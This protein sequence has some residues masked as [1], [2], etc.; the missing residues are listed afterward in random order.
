MGKRGKILI[1][2]AHG[3]VGGI[4]AKNLPYDL[5]TPTRSELDL[6][7]KEQVDQ[8]FL[9]HNIDAVIHCALTGREVLFSTEPEYTVDSLW[10]FRNLWNNKHRF[11]KLINLGTAYEFDLTKDNTLVKESDMLMHLPNTSYG[12]AKNIITRIIK[13]TDEFYNLRLFGVFHPEEANNR[14]FKKLLINR[15]ITISN[16]I[17]LDY[18]YLEDIIKFIVPIIEHRLFWKDL[19]LV[20][21]DK[22]KLSEL[23]RLFCEVQG[24]NP[25]NVKVTGVGNN[26]LTGDSSYIQTCGIMLTPFKEAFSLYKV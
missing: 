19:N 11:K 4:I 3:F 8:Y 12:Y 1:T 24:I 21:T 5:L 26:N 2:G 6:S 20:H 18:I 14:F 17:Y 25:D 9:E 23:A 10:M 13:N 22:F 15:E 7:S 16:D